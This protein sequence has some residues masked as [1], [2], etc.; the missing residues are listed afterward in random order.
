MEFE[1][2]FLYSSTYE[3]L[4]ER[5][6]SQPAKIERIKNNVVETISIFINGLSYQNISSFCSG[7]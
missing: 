1:E 5:N 7:T 6:A 2:S 3:E 4:L